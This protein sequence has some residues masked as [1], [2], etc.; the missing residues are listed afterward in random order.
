MFTAWTGKKFVG[1]WTDK[2]KALRYA[3]SR[4]FVLLE[5]DLSQDIDTTAMTETLLRE[6]AEKIARNKDKP[7]VKLRSVSVESSSQGKLH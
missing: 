1:A 5:V 4:G 7:K 3:A 6:R 2:D